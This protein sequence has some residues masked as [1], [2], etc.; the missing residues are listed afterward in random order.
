MHSNIDTIIYHPFAE[1]QIVC[2][3]P[4]RNRFRP[5]A[6][7]RVVVLENDENDHINNTVVDSRLRDDT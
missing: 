2:L 5:D 6:P 1:S 4:V 7:R 3:E